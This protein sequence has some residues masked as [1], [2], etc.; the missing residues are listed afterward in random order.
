[1]SCCIAWHK[2]ALFKWQI[3]WLLA[4][5]NVRAL[6]QHRL[7][8]ECGNVVIV[9]SFHLPFSIQN[10]SSIAQ[11]LVY[12]SFEVTQHR[13]ALLHHHFEIHE[14]LSIVEPNWPLES[15]AIWIQRLMPS[16]S[17]TFSHLDH[18]AKLLQLTPLL[19]CLGRNVK[20][21]MPMM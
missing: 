15:V 13:V 1:M 4:K 5:Q 6:H 14:Y 10:V 16:T 20:G 11:R 12:F 9:P 19:I 18:C 21:H 7:W 3:M 2:T 8:F 17:S